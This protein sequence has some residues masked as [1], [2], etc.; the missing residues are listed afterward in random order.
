VN[1]PLYS[2][3]GELS[4]VV[5]RSLWWIVRVPKYCAFF[6]YWVKLM[7]KNLFQP[8]WFIDATPKSGDQGIT[9]LKTTIWVNYVTFF[10]K[11]REY[12]CRNIFLGSIL[13]L[14]RRSGTERVDTLRQ[15]IRL[16][17][18]LTM[19]DWSIIGR[20]RLDSD[21]IHILHLRDWRLGN[22]RILLLTVDLVER[23]IKHLKQ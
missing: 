23:I 13:R 18:R 16:L 12:L 19:I 4:G 14:H 15:P 21:L 17:E 10:D 11:R 5:N 22:D 3:C 1:R 9:L 20:R 6:F 7:L 8:K 2:S